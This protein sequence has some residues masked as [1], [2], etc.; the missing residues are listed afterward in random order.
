MFEHF[1]KRSPKSGLLTTFS[2]WVCKKHRV[3]S[4][5]PNQQL[6]YICVD[7]NFTGFNFHCPL[8]DQMVQQV[9]GNLA[10][11]LILMQYL[12]YLII[13]KHNFHFRGFVQFVSFIARL[14]NSQGIPLI[15]GIRF[16]TWLVW[17]WGLAKRTPKAASSTRTKLL[18]FTASGVFW[19]RSR[20]SP[21]PCCH[22]GRHWPSLIYPTFVGKNTFQGGQSFEIVRSKGDVHVCLERKMILVTSWKMKKKHKKNPKSKNCES[23][24]PR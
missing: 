3:T 22:F 21:W 1:A 7:G 6:Q 8:A 20:G 19:R 5:W 14:P 23:K 17:E 9:T 13:K 24:I 10:Q 4:S 2:I 18:N 11:S 15:D 16:F 12:S